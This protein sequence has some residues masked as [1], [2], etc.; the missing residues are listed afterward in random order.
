MALAR[1]RVSTS[2]TTADPLD[3][4][5]WASL[6]THHAP[7]ALG[8]S[9]ARRYP[10]DVSPF[11]ALHD[12]DD[13]AAWDEL[14][15]L[16]APGETVL[17]TGA[18]VRVPP[19]WVTVL[20][21]PGVQLVAEEQVLGRIDP[22]ARL[23]DVDDPDDVTAMLDLVRRTEPGPLLPRTAALGTYLGLHHEGALIALAGERMHPTGW[24]EISAV[25]TDPAWIGR[26]LAGRLVNT[27]VAEIRARG[28][29]PLLH[30]SAGN[31]RAIRLYEHLGFRLRR[32]VDF[33][34]VRPLADST[35]EVQ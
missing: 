34:L 3:N 28:E 20:D 14:A 11:A 30:T 12:T 29:V 18:H 17:V 19:S 23:L 21:L 1:T 2:S 9:L 13:D 24:Q 22:E 15:G 27:L 31:A 5:A 33:V 8:G 7:I 10:A 25:C 35:M 4:V 16:V 26:G 6:R 32:R